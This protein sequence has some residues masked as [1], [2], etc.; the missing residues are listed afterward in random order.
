MASYY[1]RYV[2]FF[3]IS[4]NDRDQVTWNLRIP[5]ENEGYPT[6]NRRRRVN[7]LVNL[8]KSASRAAVER[9]ESRVGF[10]AY[11]YVGMGGGRY[12]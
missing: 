11:Q 10:V 5:L 2:R 3:D 6:R 8:M 1:V 9:A 7:D 12:C 4:S